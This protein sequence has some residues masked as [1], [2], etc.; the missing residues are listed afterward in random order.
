M[1]APADTRPRVVV[2]EGDPG[3]AA[4]AIRRVQRGVYAAVTTPGLAPA[5][6][7]DVV[8]EHF[9]PGGYTYADLGALHD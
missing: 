5:R 6:I 4:V 1:T 3:P 2:L 9:G 7:A 8:D